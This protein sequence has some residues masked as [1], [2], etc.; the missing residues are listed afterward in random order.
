MCQCEACTP[1]ADPRNSDGEQTE[2]EILSISSV[3]NI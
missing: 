1:H 3:V 2:S